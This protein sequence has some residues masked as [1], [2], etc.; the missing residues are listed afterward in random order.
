MEI[1]KKLKT[2][3]TIYKFNKIIQLKQIKRNIK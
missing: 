1:R 2:K 3:R